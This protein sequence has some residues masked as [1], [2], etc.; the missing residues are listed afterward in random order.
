[1]VTCS[2]LILPTVYIYIYLIFPLGHLLS[3]SQNFQGMTTD[4]DSSEVQEFMAISMQLIV[5]TQQYLSYRIRRSMLISSY[6]PTPHVLV[7][8][9]SLLQCTHYFKSTCMEAGNSSTPGQIHFSKCLLVLHPF[10][11]DFVKKCTESSIIVI[12]LIVAK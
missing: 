12:I 6:T 8:V 5:N 10:E 7:L 4:M 9:W 11:K 1:M 2:T 3:Q